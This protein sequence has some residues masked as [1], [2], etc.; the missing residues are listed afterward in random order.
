MY[1][2]DITKESGIVVLRNLF[3]Q[4]DHYDDLLKKDFECVE[5][6]EEV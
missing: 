1:D 5:R 2:M 6:I 3:R 4:A